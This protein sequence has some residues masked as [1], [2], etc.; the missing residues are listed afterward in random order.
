[1]PQEMIYARESRLVKEQRSRLP[2]QMMLPR[3]PREKEMNVELVQPGAIRS[4]ELWP[5]PVRLL[6]PAQM[7]VVFLSKESSNQYAS[8][9]RLPCMI[10]SSSDREDAMGLEFSRYYRLVLPEDVDKPFL[11][12]HPLTWGPISHIIWDGLPPESMSVS[13]QQA[14]LDWLHWGGQLV[15]IGGAGPTF[16]IFRESFLARYLPAEPTGENHLLGE[17][18][19]KPLADAYP[20]TVLPTLPPDQENAPV[21]VQP[22]VFYQ[23]GRPYRKAVPIQPPRTRPVFVTGLRARPGAATISLGEGSPHLLA[24]EGRVGRGRITMLTINP[25]DPSL[26]SWPGLDTLIRRV[27]LRRPEEVAGAP[28]S[29]DPAA[30]FSPARTMLEG[31]DLSWYRITSRDAGAESEA[32]RARAVQAARATPTVNRYGVPVPPSA[33]GRLVECG[34]RGGFAQSYGG[35]GMARHDRVAPGL[36][37]SAREGRGH[38]R[39]QLAVRSQGDPGLHS[40]RR[41]AQLAGLPVVAQSPGVGLDRGA[42]AR[43]GVCGRGRA[44]GRL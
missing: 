10:P 25:T 8:W 11:S 35:C 14:M 7:L 4:D 16:S 26:V 5:V 6:P 36:P 42:L 32:A 20:P 38:H 3:I 21:R 13:H 29:N 41:S 23:S 9:T 40:R 39:P 27:V 28:P 43:A 31:P 30:A 17:A 19:L 15:L 18:E 22:E 44:D 33:G 37:R 34:G 2:M 1:M 12:P 24:V